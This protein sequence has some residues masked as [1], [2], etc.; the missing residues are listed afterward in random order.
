MDVKGIDHIAINAIDIEQSIR[1]Y[2]EV[3]RFPLVER[4]PNGDNTLVYL[5][6]TADTMLELFD[7]KKEIKYHSH[8]EDA[9]GLVHFALTVNGIE[10]WN[11]HLTQHNVTFTLPLCSLSHLGKKVLLFKDPNGA[12]IEL[13]EEL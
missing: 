5:R 11:E 10:E 2:E 9:S 12:I 3:L 4:V 13:C 1:F 8:P 7:H 6:I